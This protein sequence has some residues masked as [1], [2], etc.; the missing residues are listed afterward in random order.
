MSKA[1]SGISSPEMMNALGIL[2]KMLN[3]ASIY[4]MNHPSVSGPMK[5][6][7]QVLSDA[8]RIEKKVALG[9]FNKTLTIND[10]MISDYT[11]HLRALERKFITLNIPHLVFRNGI[12]LD[13]LTQLVNALCTAGNQSGP[14]IKEQLDEAG[15]DHIKADSVEYVAQHEGEHL[16]GDDEGGRNGVEGDGDGLDEEAAEEKNE[17]EEETPP[18]IQIEQIVAF[19]KGDPSSA[20]EP[21]TDE[22]Q[23]MLSDPEKLGQLIMES[24]SVRQSMQSL[25]NGESLADIVIGCLR[26][27]YEGLAQQK[28]FKSARGKAS[29]HKAMLLLEKTVV[30]KIRNAVG[31]E[32]P[33]VDE[34]ILEALREAEEQRQVEILAARFAEQHKKMTKTELDV[35][36]Y[37]RKHGE[38]KARALLDSEDIP[39]QEWNRL[40]IQSRNSR[41]G[42]GE[43]TGAGS[44][45]GEVGGSGDNIDMGA[46]AIVLD[47]LDTIMHLD[48]TPPEII[49][50]TVDDVRENVEAATAK[51]EKQVESLE[52]QVL[53]HEEDLILPPEN[54]RSNKSR[55]DLLLQISQLAL[56]LSQPLT[57]ITA[58]IEA[59]LLQTTQPALQHE[60][61]ELANESGQRMKELMDRLTRLVGYPS[62]KEADIGIPG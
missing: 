1:I 23:E 41:T 21:P 7:H 19:L 26:R 49:K 36:N 15:M 2:G 20:S 32:Q 44:E 57:V 33:E 53:Q 48:N 59:A 62:M 38:E 8:L 42:A 10:K 46:L 25:E 16:V 17:E 37:I 52:S 40:M 5:E 45:S 55:A 50:S 27:T 18:P 56:K 35:L 14:S 39:E 60:L 22:L 3:I 47:K 51:V 30:D 43:G 4:G 11:V 58:S 34:Q 29:L 28:K 54:R 12:T 13:E 6:A 31:E 9:L 24:V 61:L